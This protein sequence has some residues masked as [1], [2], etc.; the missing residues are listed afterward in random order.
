MTEHV[1]VYGI[2]P[3]IQYTADGILTTYEFP[4]A[5]FKASDLDVYFGDSLQDTDT[6]TVSGVGN[7]DGGS[8]TFSSAPTADTIITITRDL[9]I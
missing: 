5:I 9:S 3:R 8:V 7:S 6:Y 1:K 4:F 2:K